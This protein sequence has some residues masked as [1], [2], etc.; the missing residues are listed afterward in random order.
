MNTKR[1]SY[2]ENSLIKDSNVGKSGIGIG[3]REETEFR[4][5]GTQ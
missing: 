5:E 2:K 1:H 4:V 3:R